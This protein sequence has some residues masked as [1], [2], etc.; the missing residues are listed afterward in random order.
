M[1][2]LHLSVQRVVDAGLRINIHKS[3]IMGISVSN[4][5]VTQAATKKPIWIKWKNVL[6]PID[7]GGL[8]ISSFYALN[9]ALLFKWIWRFYTQDTSLYAKVIKGI[10]GEDGKIGKAVSNLYSSTWLDIVKEIDSLNQ[11]CMNFVGYIHKKM[12]NGLYTY[13]WDDIWKGDIALKILYPRIYALETNKNISV[14]SNLGQNNLGLSL[15]RIP[16]GGVEQ[17]QLEALREFSDNTVLV[18]SMDRWSWSLE[19]SG[20]F[21]VA[22]VR[23]EIDKKLLPMVSSKTRWVNEV[24][25]KVNI[26]AWKVKLDCLPTRL[27]I[28]RRGHC[29]NFGVLTHIE[30]SSDDASSSTPPTDEWLT[31]DSI[32]K[33]WMFLTLS[34]TLRKR[35]IKANPN[36]AKAAW[37]TIETI[38]Q[39]NKRTRTVALK[40]ELRMI[41]MEEH[42]AEEYFSKIDSIITLL[43]DLGSDVSEEDVVTY[44]INGLSDKYGSLAQIIAHKDPFPDLATVRSMVTTEEMRIRSKPSNLPSN[45]TSNAPQVLLAEANTN[46]DNTGRNTRERDTS[47]RINNRTTEVCRNFGRGFCRWGASCKFIHGPSRYTGSRNTGQSSGMRNSIVNNSMYAGLGHTGTELA[48]HQ[49]LLNLLQAQ[50]SLL[51]QYGISNLAGSRQSGYNSLMGPRPTIPTGLQS[52]PQQAA[53]YPFTPQQQALFTNTVQGSNVIWS[54]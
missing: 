34:S 39:D 47:S 24:P 53:H 40:G 44:A 25:K 3:K 54:R 7:K 37:D 33:S 11:Q 15:R 23:R 48:G 2:S 6:A 50:N 1:E 42:T 38:F 14:A 12:G 13:F 45:N 49:Q 26:H 19:G 4:D 20:N 32:V 30:G 9:R 36:T 22:S 31:A 5:K 18:D 10:H 41:Q 51:A 46:R 43:N 21:S 27:N 28:S 35:M 16:R 52:T 29:T 17:S 8:G